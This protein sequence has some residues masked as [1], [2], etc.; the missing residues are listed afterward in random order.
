MTANSFIKNQI[1]G[2]VG[3]ITLDRPQALN[4]LNWDMVTAIHE[5]LDAWEDLIIKAVVIRSSNPKFFCSGGDIK[6]IQQLVLQEKADLGEGFFST[7]YMLNKRIANYPVPVISLISGL[8]LGGGL[9]LSVHGQFRVVTETAKMAMPETAIGFFPDVGA[10]YF[11]PRLPGAIGMYLGLTGQ[12]MDYRD[13]LYC[14][15]ATHYM[16]SESIGGLVD[17]LNDS[18]DQPVAQVISSAC[19][20]PASS[21]GHLAKHRSEIDWC[22]GAGTLSEIETRLQVVNSDWSQ[23]VSSLLHFASPQSL[24]TTYAMIHQG[25]EL[26]LEDCLNLEFRVASALIRSDDFVEGVRA[27]LVDKDGTPVWSPR[28]WAP[29]SQLLDSTRS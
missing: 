13:A 7:E 20:L 17:F 11:L 18:R 29:L 16:S 10:S 9:G 19:V 6:R 14:G 5:V 22:F 15:L 26:S 24:E 4:A 2:G 8:C 21:Y 27:A 23:K 1:L 28:V 12:R 25:S 3:I